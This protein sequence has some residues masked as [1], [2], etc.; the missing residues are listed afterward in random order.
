MRE[1]IEGVDAYDS[2]LILKRV[3]PQELIEKDDYL[4]LTVKIPKVDLVETVITRDYY[5]FK[6]SYDSFL[7]I[8]K[9]GGDEYVVNFNGII[10]K[11]RGIAGIKTTEKKY[12]YSLT[13]LF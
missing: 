8:K 3:F 12:W 9:I 4:T 13:F 1:Y 6:Y 10:L 2:Y 5:K 11:L 7:I